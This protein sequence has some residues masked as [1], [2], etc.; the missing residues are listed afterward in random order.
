M[1]TP[2]T[3]HPDIAAALGVPR[4]YLKRE[5]LHP[6][7]SHKGRSIPTMIDIKAADGRKE[8]AI[9]SSGNAALAAIRHIVHKNSGLKEE[10][11]RLSLS[12]IVGERIDTDKEQILIVEAKNAGETSAGRISISQS[13]RPLKA[14]FDLIKGNRHD[15]LRQSVDDNALIGYESLAAELARTPE[16]AAVFIPTSSGTAAQAIAEFFV[17]NKKPSAVHIVQTTSCHPIV[18][19]F[20]RADSSET[21]MADAIVDKVAYRRAKLVEVIKKT[22]G[23]GWIATNTEIAR[24]QDL[25]R[26]SGVETTANGALGLAGLI[27]AC[28]KGATFTGSV[29]CVITGK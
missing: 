29:V 14:L 2:Q 11:D 8:F 26:A 9:S 13:P 19:G 15:S 27:R 10:E 21:S 23:S 6:Y 5:D 17:A 20:D 12:I 28:A 22:A 16:L 25:L 3:E 18:N 24:A 1:I 7:G 4:L